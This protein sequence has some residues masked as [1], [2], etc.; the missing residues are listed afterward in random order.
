MGTFYE[1][2][3]TNDTAREFE[4]LARDRAEA[5]QPSQQVE[6]ARLPRGVEAL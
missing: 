6:N 1:G 4:Q 2:R 3:A 5:A